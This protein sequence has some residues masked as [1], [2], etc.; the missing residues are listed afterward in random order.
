MVSPVESVGHTDVLKSSAT[1]F[2]T[3]AYS[4]RYTRFKDLP[5]TALG[6]VAAANTL[7]PFSILGMLFRVEMIIG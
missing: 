1:L 5:V 3:T 4:S 2:E 6:L 7:E